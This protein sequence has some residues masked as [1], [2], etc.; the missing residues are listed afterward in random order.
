MANEIITTT[1]NGMQIA[2]VDMTSFEGTLAVANALT[3]AGSMDKELE[4]GK[5]FE[6][7]GAV[8]KDGVNDNTGES[9][10]E[11]Y[12]ILR[13]GTALFSKSQGIYQSA[14]Q[15]LGLL[16]GW[17]HE[18]LWAEVVSQKTGKGNTIKL[19]KPIAPPAK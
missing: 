11:S 9:C 14:M 8:F 6:F 15:I 17:L 7:V 18:G 16:G 10:K 1:D 3:V 4:E 12:F 19:L 5:S 13:D 2:G